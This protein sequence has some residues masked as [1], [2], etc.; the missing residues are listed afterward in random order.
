[1]Q[2]LKIME[3]FEKL[4]PMLKSRNVLTLGGVYEAGRYF[5]ADVWLLLRGCI[6]DKILKL[7]FVKILTLTM[8]ISDVW[9]RF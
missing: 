6:M 1:M 7:D 2:I 3:N 8:L 5:A 9:L 4:R